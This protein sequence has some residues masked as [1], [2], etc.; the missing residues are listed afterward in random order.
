MGVSIFAYWPGI[1][2]RQL[3]EQPGFANDRFPDRGEQPEYDSVDSSLWYVIAVHDYLGAA[4]AR[5]YR[6][7]HRAMIDAVEAILTGYIAG[8]RY[9]IRMDTDGLLAAASAACS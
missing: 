3:A 8:T 2:E 4:A 9:R 5:G 1:T 7:E 6:R